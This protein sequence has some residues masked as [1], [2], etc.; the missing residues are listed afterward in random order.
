MG[1]I[2][3]GGE[4]AQEYLADSGE[5]LAAIETDLMAIEKGGAGIDEEL[6]NRGPPGGHTVVAPAARGA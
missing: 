5:R 6:V 1:M 2:D 4:M 3:P